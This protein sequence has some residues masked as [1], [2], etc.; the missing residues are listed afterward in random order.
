MENREIS[1]AMSVGEHIAYMAVSQDDELLLVLCTEEAG[2]AEEKSWILMVL[3]P[4]GQEILQTDITSFLPKGAWND[5]SWICDMEED[6][7]GYISVIG[8][9]NSP[10]FR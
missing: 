10:C 7:E 8:G 5:E 4:S 1:V 6:G 3:D 9:G 2:K